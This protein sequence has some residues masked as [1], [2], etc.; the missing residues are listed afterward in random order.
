MADMVT[1]SLDCPNISYALTEADAKG[2]HIQ[3]P[4]CD[5]DLIITV[6]GSDYVLTVVV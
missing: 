2:N 4:D 1:F 3:C 6:D 5:K